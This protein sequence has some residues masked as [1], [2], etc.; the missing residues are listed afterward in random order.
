MRMNVPNG[1]RVMNCTPLVVRMF[2]SSSLFVVV[3]VVVDVS[4]KMKEWE[5]ASSSVVACVR[6]NTLTPMEGRRRRSLVPSSEKQ[7]M[8]EWPLAID[9]QDGKVELSLP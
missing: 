4:F 1:D 8:D 5:L 6:S 3:D 2:S 7:C 9:T